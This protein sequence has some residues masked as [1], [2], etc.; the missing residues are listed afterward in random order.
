MKMVL[1]DKEL[2]RYRKILAVEEVKYL[3]SVIK[4]GEPNQQ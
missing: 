4:D 1:S 3:T 2:N